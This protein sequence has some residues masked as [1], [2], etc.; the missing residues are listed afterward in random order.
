MRELFNILK[1]I[2]SGALP[3]GEVPG[4]MLWAVKKSRHAFLLALIV[5]AAV[6]W[7]RA[8]VGR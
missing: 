1:D 8:R 7:M 5:A 2:R 4:F 3:A 6:L